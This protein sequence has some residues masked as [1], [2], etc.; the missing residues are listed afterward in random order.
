MQTLTNLQANFIPASDIIGALQ[1]IAS[2]K[3]YQESRLVVPLGVIS[4]YQLLQLD[5]SQALTSKPH[6]P[7]KAYFPNTNHP[8]LKGES[9]SAIVNEC[10]QQLDVV[11][12]DAS[13]LETV[14]VG[15]QNLHQSL[16]EQQDK[17]IQSRH[18]HKGFVSALWRLPTETLSYIFH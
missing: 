13:A 7:G 11:L 5:H 8:D 10:K 6:T 4:S 17:I 3:S 15:I 12:H 18:L 1:N 9:I 16:V 14:M 2:I